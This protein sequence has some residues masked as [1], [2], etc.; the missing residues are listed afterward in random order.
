MIGLGLSIPQVAVRQRFGPSSP[1]RGATS[2]FVNLAAAANI[3]FPVGAAVGDSLAISV[4]HSWP[5][6][7]LV[8]TGANVGIWNL[9]GPNYNGL[10]YYGSLAAADV[11]R[12]YIGFAWGGS[13]YGIVSLVCFRGAKTYLDSGGTRQSAGAPS[14]TVSTAGAVAA[15]STLLLMGSAYLATD[16]TSASLSADLIHNPNANASGVCRFGLAGA[17][18]VQS[19]T[20]DYA[21]APGGDYQVIMAFA[22]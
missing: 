3:P 18:G 5:L 16:A 11:A 14:R 19:G 22:P 21:G 7:G 12:G 1:I 17:A 4:G 20:V 13:G 15:G 2:V 8:W 10:S 6:N 9:Q